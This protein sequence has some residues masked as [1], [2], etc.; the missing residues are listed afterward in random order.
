MWTL[1]PLSCVGEVVADLRDELVAKAEPE[2]R[3]VHEELVKGCG[4]TGQLGVV[5][6]EWSDTVRPSRG[7]LEAIVHREGERA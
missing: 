3:I 2:G 5:Q 4:G 1:L 7:R 6:T